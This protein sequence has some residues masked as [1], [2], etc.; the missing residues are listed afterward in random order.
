MLDQPA[1]LLA[2]MTTALNVYRAFRSY[3]N[4]ASQAEFIRQAPELWKIYGEVISMRYQ[5][6]Q[7]NG[8]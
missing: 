4:A 2:K 3:R 6:E 1:G 7:T 5:D 8:K